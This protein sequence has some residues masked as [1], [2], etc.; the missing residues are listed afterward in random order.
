MNRTQNQ[1]DM[2]HGPL[3]GNLLLFTLPIALSSILQ[4]LFN[5]TDTAIA[6]Y[7]GSKDALASVGANGEIIALI[8]TLSSGLS[9][10]VNLLIARQIGKRNRNQ[11]SDTSTMTNSSLSEMI[12]TIRTSLFLAWMIGII[13]ALI[14]QIVARPL[15]T[16]IQTPESIFSS[17]KL[18]LRIYLAC[19]PFLLLYDF[20][21]AILRAQ[22]DSRSPFLALVIS[23]V[24]NVLLNLLFVIV[25]HLGVAGIAIATDL[26]TL[27]SAIIVQCKIIRITGISKTMKTTQANQ[28]SDIAEILK[29]GIPSAVQGA[30]FCFAN[31]F[32]QASVNRFGAS[33]I[34]GSTIAMNFEYF[35]YYGIT[36]FGQTATTFT[37]QNY[38]AGKIKR[39]RKILWLCLG[40]STLCALLMIAPIVLFRTSF[41]K[42]FS[43]DSLVI[44]YASLRIL[45]IL[46]FEPICGFY[47]V[48][49]G[50]LRGSGH[51][52]LPTIST[53]IGTCA[54]RIIWICTVFQIHPSLEVLYHA[55]PLSWICTIFLIGFSFFITKPLKMLPDPSDLSA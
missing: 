4:Q 46:F 30:V 12:P 39:C 7:F 28:I 33:A 43:P 32:V 51:A 48:P 21:S 13:G 26:S 45:C 23:G 44:E 50:V 20:G 1:I 31:I 27:L 38:S 36:A 6:G 41:C 14:G 2:I 25:F 24:V 17:A 5:A 19:Y 8:V 11:N 9:I 10:G 52:L 54:F 37:C 55:F 15:L 40:Y 29:M 16:L 35:A 53:M 49:A 18:Y 3:S 42:A 47:E 34:A 22:G